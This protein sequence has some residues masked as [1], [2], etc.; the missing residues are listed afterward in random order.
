[1]KIKEINDDILTFN[2]SN[3]FNKHVNGCTLNN[4]TKMYIVYDLNDK[5]IY[6]KTEP[7]EMFV[8]PDEIVP[9]HTSN[10]NDEDIHHNGNV[11][12]ISGDILASCQKHILDF[13]EKNNL[14][15]T[16]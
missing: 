3:V 10:V 8:S 2:N 7:N 4:G 1:M 5:K 6:I 14:Y 13:F 12:S 11:L 15:I 16:D 9:I